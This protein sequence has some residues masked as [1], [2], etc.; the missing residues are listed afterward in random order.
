LARTSE[1]HAASSTQRPWRRQ[2]VLRGLGANR[3]KPLKMARNHG[4]P[5]EGPKPEATGVG[6]TFPFP[7]FRQASR[8]AGFLFLSARTGPPCCSH[9]PPGSSPSSQYPQPLSALRYPLSAL[10]VQ[11]LHECRVQWLAASQQFQL[12]QL[13]APSSS[14]RHMAGPGNDPVQVFR[15]GRAVYLE[16]L[17]LWTGFELPSSWSNLPCYGV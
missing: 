1:P 17:R 11:C 15:T 3:Q 4:P 12:P 10:S 2:N 14:Q 5:N 13:P 9:Q 8:A 6:A 7:F 16:F